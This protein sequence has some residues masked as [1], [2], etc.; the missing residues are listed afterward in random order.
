MSDPAPEFERVGAW[1]DTYGPY[2]GAL[3]IPEALDG[4]VLL[5]MRDDVPHIA[6]PGKWGL[7]GGGIEDGETPHVAVV[8]ELEEETG[9]V[10]PADS[11]T[12][13]YA[14]LTGEPNWGLLYIFHLKADLDARDVVMLEGGGFALAT[15]SQ[16]EKLDLIPYVRDVLDVFWARP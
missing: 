9:L 11:F 2:R 1:R 13:I 5:Q 16:A 15:R 4:R 7:F 3:V 6:A 12:P 10:H 14:S 8:R